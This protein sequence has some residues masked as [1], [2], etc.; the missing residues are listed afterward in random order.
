MLIEVGEWMFDILEEHVEEAAFLWGQ[1][2]AALM[3]PSFDAPALRRLEARIAAHTD[4]LVLAGPAV[5]PIL[6]QKLAGERDEALAAAHA[7]LLSGESRDARAVLAALR[8]AEGPA[9]DGLRLALC[10]APVDAI[11]PAVQ[12]LLRTAPAPAAAAA[13]EAL[14]FHDAGGVSSAD[15]ARFVG[16]EDAAVREAG[17][18]TG[19]WLGTA[20]EPSLYA[21]ALRDDTPA[22]RS[23]ALH[24]AA[25]CRVPGA[26]QVVRKAAT[27]PGPEAFALLHL[28]SVLGTTEDWP[29]IRQLGGSEVL[30]PAR[31]QLLAAYGRPESAE[32]MIAAMSSDDPAVAAAAGSAFMRMTGL[33]VEA[34][35]ATVPAQ[36]ETDDVEAEFLDEVP[37]P[38]PEL[39]R[40]LW[41]DLQPAV[42]NAARLCHGL[43]A[44]LPLASPALEG[45][46][47]QSRWEIALR[48]RFRGTTHATAAAFQRFPMEPASA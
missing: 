35:R 12:E 13:A 9:L 39:A 10:L 46:D 25:W 7:L 38:D 41:K 34:G 6:E 36:D 15:V 31:F 2:Q 24:A 33:D 23:A 14:A 4:A 45:M 28:L 5:R 40:Q 1:R 8:E 11:A 47:M 27:Q 3:S 19:T 26:L 18:R 37:V 30:G 17:W 22:V 29:V 21:A 16:H 48:G 42:A 32:D 20:A 43:D 44:E